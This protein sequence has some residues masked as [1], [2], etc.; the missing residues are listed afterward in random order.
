[1]AIGASGAASGFGS[2]WQLLKPCEEC[3]GKGKLGEGKDKEDCP[4]CDGFGKIALFRFGKIALFR[5]HDMRHS[6]A[7]FAIAAGLDIYTLSRRLGHLYKGNDG[8]AHAIDA[9]LG[10]VVTPEDASDSPSDTE[11]QSPSAAGEG[12]DEE[13]GATRPGKGRKPGRAN[14]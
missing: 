5:F 11:D 10:R 8:D 4:A 2:A 13:P 14:I 12:L 6:Y 3:R 7:A 1:M 9:F